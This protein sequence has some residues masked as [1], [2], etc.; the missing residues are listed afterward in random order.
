M[1][2]KDVVGQRAIWRHLMQG[3]QEERIPH[4]QLFAGPPG[5]G[6]LAMAIVYARYLVCNGKGKSDMFSTGPADGPCGH[7]PSCVKMNKLVHPDVH[8]MMP[9]FKK[10]EGSHDKDNYPQSDDFIYEWREALLDNPYMD[11]NEWLTIAGASNQQGEIFVAQANEIIRKLSLRSSEGGYRVV[12]VWLPEKMNDACANK[13]LKLIEEPPSETVFILVSNEAERILPTIQSRCQRINFRP[14]AEADIRDELVS[15]F[16]LE[17]ATAAQIA[18]T[19]E[20]SWAKALNTLNTDDATRQYTELF[21]RLMRCSYAR[22]LKEMREWSDEVAQLGRS[23]QKQ[24]LDYCQR[25]IRESFMANFREPCLN[26][27]NTPEKEFT[28]RFAPFVNEK[29]IIGISEVLSDAARDIESNVNA[30]MVF[31][32]LSLKMIMLLKNGNN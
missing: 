29:N 23:T 7:C 27:M 30:K 26:Y 12:I 2:F 13:L 11:L 24:F 19:G 28:S 8:F 1:Y 15:R 6:K 17:P 25:M 9:L 20:G 5:T 10:K 3:V 4:A 32:D 14:I 22:W 16:Q 18:H 31:F 21:I